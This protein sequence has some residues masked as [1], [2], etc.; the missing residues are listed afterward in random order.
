MKRPID[1]SLYLVTDDGSRGADVAALVARA[2]EGGVTC[3]QVRDKA[4]STRRFVAR[5]HEVLAVARPKG[6]AVLVNDR[7][8]VALATDADG[9]HVGQDDLDPRTAHALLGS[10]RILGVTAGDPQAA[11][12]AADDGADYV[13][14][15]AVFPTPTKADAG[16]PIGVL[17]LAAIVRAVRLPVVGIG[18]IDRTNAAGVMTAGVAGI[19]VVNAICGAADPR[20]AAEE[21]ARIVRASRAEVPR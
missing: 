11:R 2:I 16:A 8:D 18:G 1:L 14:S 9:L 21:L 7:L 13:G 12:R 10:E 17:G 3:V 20:L 4:G 19:A 5:V 6:V 15:T